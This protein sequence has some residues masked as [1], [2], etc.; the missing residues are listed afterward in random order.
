MDDEQASLKYHFDRILIESSRIIT[1]TLPG[2]T[3]VLN[4]AQVEMLRNCVH[5]LD[6]RSSFVSEYGDLTY[7]TPDDSDWDD[8]RAIVADLEELLMGD[9][10]VPFGVYDR[11]SEWLGGTK[12][13]DGTYSAVSTAVPADYVYVVQG[14]FAQ[15]DTMPRGLT[16]IGF[17]DDSY[18]YYMKSIVP[19]LASESVSVLAPMVLKQGDQ[20]RVIVQSCLDGDVISAGARGYKMKV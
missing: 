17:S 14:V 19:T 7:E 20:V 3:V 11:W 16:S 1:P 5:Y 2:C 4:G 6:R 13:G 9:V 8:I 12:S 10:N 18:W 15:N